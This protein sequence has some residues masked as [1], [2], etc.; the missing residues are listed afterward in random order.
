[1]SHIEIYQPELF[2]NYFNIKITK[3]RRTTNNCI[4]NKKKPLFLLFLIC[5]LSFI[6]EHS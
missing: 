6:N 1:M 5:V 4:T 3:K 2:Q